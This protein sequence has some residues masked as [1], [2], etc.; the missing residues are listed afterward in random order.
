MFK[1]TTPQF[2]NHNTQT[3]HRRSG[4]ILKTVTE[5][6]IISCKA[7]M[8]CLK[9]PCT[10]CEHALHYAATRNGAYNI[11]LIWGGIMFGTIIYFIVYYSFKHLFGKY[12]LSLV[13]FFFHFTR[14]VRTHDVKTGKHGS[15]HHNVDYRTRMLLWPVLCILKFEC[16]LYDF[17][18]RMRFW[19]I[20]NILLTVARLMLM[21]GGV[22]TK[23]LAPATLTQNYKIIVSHVARVILSNFLYRNRCLKLYYTGR[24]GFPNSSFF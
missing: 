7:E 4:A 11:L 20:H 15:V 18:N 2:N 14:F 3:F 9:E 16:V 8:F 10:R 6:R 24:G 19:Q 22:Q 12:F 21:G 5:N 13:F 17:T 23:H 1:F